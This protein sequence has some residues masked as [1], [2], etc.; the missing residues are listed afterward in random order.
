MK[1]PTAASQ[2]KVTAENLLT[3]GAERLAEILVSVAETRVDL[4]RWLRIELAAQQGPGPLTGEIDKRLAAFATSRGR[5][6]WRAGPAFV[7]DLDALRDLINVRLAPLDASAAIERLWRFMDVAPQSASRYRD[8][9]GGL[10]A[11]FV[12]AAGDLGHLL[13]SVPHHHAATALV[14]SGS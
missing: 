3:L 7:R 2:K 10:E 6:N 11:I 13:G 9:N 5:V 1:K 14:E 12:R 4:K 8:R